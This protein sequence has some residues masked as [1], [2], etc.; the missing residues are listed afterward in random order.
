LADD[1]RPTWQ[2]GAADYPFPCGSPDGQLSGGSPPGEL[3]QALTAT[4]P[5]SW[6]HNGPVVDAAVCPMCAPEH[7]DHDQDA[8]NAPRVA[9]NPAPYRATFGERSLS[10]GLLGS[11]CTVRGP[12]CSLLTDSLIRLI[13]LVISR[14]SSATECRFPGWGGTRATQII[15]ADDVLDRFD[16]AKSSYGIDPHAVRVPESQSTAL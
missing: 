9:R 14:I 5:P 3:M 16:G 1:A 13:A 6:Q 11:F 8:R 7:H 15:D 12:V 10:R 2:G 4:H